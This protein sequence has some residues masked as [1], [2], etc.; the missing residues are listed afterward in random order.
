VTKTVVK[1][2]VLG[3]LFALVAAR[4]ALAYIDPNTGG[5]LFQIL[6]TAFGVISGFALIFSRQIRTAVAR[7]ARKLRGLRHQDAASSPQVDPG[8]TDDEIGV[9]DGQ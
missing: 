5:L 3:L 8:T 1:S 2:L 4:P 7:I 6:A 9:S